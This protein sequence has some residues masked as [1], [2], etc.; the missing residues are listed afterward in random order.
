MPHAFIASPLP[1]PSFRTP[2]VR[3]FD[4]PSVSSTASW[5]DIA[6]NQENARVKR[7]VNGDSTFR[8]ETDPRFDLWTCRHH[9]A[10]RDLLWR[11]VWNDL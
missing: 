9:Q 1:K 7:Q 3:P 10:C 8:G 2:P 4:L 6:P 5:L 11:D